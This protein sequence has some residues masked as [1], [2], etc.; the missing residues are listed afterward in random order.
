MAV[1]FGNTYLMKPTFDIGETVGW[2][3]IQ[4]AAPPKFSIST[5]C[6]VDIHGFPWIFLQTVSSPS[7]F[8]YYC[9]IRISGG[10]EIIIQN[11]KY[12]LHGFLG[13]TA[14]SITLEVPKNTLT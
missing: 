7:F 14:L 3:Q 9:M 4:D 2:T 5:G 8:L 13:G 11:Y 10:C 6:E 1:H 12:R